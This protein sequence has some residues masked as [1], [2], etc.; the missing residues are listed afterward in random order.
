MFRDFCKA[1]GSICERPEQRQA[2][3]ALVAIPALP[4]DIDRERVRRPSDFEVFE[5]VPFVRLRVICDI[6]AALACCQE[7]AAIKEKIKPQ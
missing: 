2:F 1:V 4:S 3:P 5:I 7:S 6:S